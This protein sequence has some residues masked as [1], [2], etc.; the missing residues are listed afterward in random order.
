MVLELFSPFSSLPGEYVGAAAQDASLPD[1]PV[2][3]SPEENDEMSHIND[4]GL[5]QVTREVCESARNHLNLQNDDICNICKCLF[6][7]IE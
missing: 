5:V 1:V 7:P 3:T 6:P 4:S 2:L